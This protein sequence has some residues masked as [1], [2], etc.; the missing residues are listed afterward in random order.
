MNLFQ[1]DCCAW[2]LRREVRTVPASP[3]S[4]PALCEAC[5]AALELRQFPRDDGHQPPCGGSFAGQV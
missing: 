4:S 1:F 2:R 5:R 3:G